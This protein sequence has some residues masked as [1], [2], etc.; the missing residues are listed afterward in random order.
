MNMNNKEWTD[1]NGNRLLTSRYGKSDNTTKS[2]VAPVQLVSATGHLYIFRLSRMNT[3]V[4]NRFIL[5]GMKN[6]LVPKLEVR[7]RRS[8]EKYRPDMGAKRGETANTR[9]PNKV[10]SLDYRD[11]DGNAFYELALK[12]SFINSNS[13]FKTPKWSQEYH[14]RVHR[15]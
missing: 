8:R 7:F 3:L 1:N 15:A 9:T 13:Q 11:M 14:H 5:D 6:E 4:V 2:A 10:D 12:L